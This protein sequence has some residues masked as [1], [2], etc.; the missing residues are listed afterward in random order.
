MRKSDTEANS[1]EAL[2][3]LPGFLGT[4]ILLGVSSRMESHYFAIL[5]WEEAQLSYKEKQQGERDQSS[6]SYSTPAVL[7]WL[8]HILVLV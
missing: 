6:L 1:E 5:H 4:L 8:L 3:S 2:Q 7:A